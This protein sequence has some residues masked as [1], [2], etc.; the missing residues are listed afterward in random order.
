MITVNLDDKNVVENFKALNELRKSGMFTDEQLQQMYDK[1]VELD[2]ERDEEEMQSETNNGLIGFTSS[3]NST[4]RLKKFL[5]H[6][7]FTKMR[8]DDD[9]T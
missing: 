8:G 9:E 1:Q 2:R 4:S 7:P 3:K 5:N 6:F